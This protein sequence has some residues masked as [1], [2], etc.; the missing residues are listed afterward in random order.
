MMES[1]RWCRRATR[2]KCTHLLG[3]SLAV[4]REGSG[5]L[6]GEKGNEF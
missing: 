2:R 1:R 4:E 5:R 3:A 6:V